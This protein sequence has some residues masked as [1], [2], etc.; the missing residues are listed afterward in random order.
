MLL[1]HCVVEVF[2]SLL[3]RFRFGFQYLNRYLN[4][5]LNQ[6]DVSDLPY[7]PIKL[8]KNRE[9][10]AVVVE[11]VKSEP[12]YSSTKTTCILPATKQPALSCLL[13]NFIQFLLQN[14][15]K[16]FKIYLTA[17]VGELGMTPH[18]FTTGAFLAAGILFIL[19]KTIT[20]CI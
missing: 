3:E 5:S 8:F 12:L 19:Y 18:Q 6:S 4:P 10:V 9:K 13:K 2:S 1:N 15:Q 11:E 16:L 7:K 17:H 14:P 20:N